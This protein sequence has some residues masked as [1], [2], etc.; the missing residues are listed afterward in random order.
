[1]DIF[2]TVWKGLNDRQ[3][4]V[5]SGRF[6]L[7][8]TKKV[9]T[10]AALGKRYGITRERVRQIEANA[11]RILREQLSANSEWTTIFNQ[12]KK[13]LKN[14]GGVGRREDV[15][16]HMRSVAGDLSEQQLAL[17]L[18]ASG[19]VT[20]HDD[21]D[22][23]WP[24]YSLDKASLQKATHFVEQWLSYLRTNKQS[25]LAGRYTDLLKKFI[26]AKGASPQIANSFLSISKHVHVNPYGDVGLA[27]WPEIKPVTIRDRIY[28]VLKKK[29]E[30]LHFESIAKTINEAGFAARPALA[31]T[32]HNELIKDNRFVLVG[33]GMYGLSEHGYQ[34][35]TARE[36]IQKI[37]K[38][39]GPMNTRQ[40]ILAI[41]KERFLKPNTV[42]V[43]LQNKEY[44][45]RLDDGRYHV[46]ES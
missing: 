30:P 15:L 31:P 18:A 9:Q 46:R 39:S 34:A 10:L 14:N 23:T 2:T 13:Y 17:L 37:L 28:L 29:G 6:G 27:E 24:F 45:K 33:R 21:T 7:D 1:M 11:L 36:V 20:L 43:N 19:E 38:K 40:I 16:A 42:L 25:A 41:Q 32:V 3:Q 8:K 12:V 35:G 22:T 26:K 5:L 44:F 4:E